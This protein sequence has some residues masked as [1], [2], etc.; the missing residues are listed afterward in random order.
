MAVG[1]VPVVQCQTYPE[2][3]LRKTTGVAKHT[4]QRCRRNPEHAEGQTGG[5]EIG[6]RG[7]G[8]YCGKGVE[9]HASPSA[10]RDT[11]AT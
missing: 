4:A 11:G 2:A 1:I 9:G 7:T 8:S 3:A 10:W 6:L 5:E